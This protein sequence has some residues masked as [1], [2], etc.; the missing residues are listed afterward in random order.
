MAGFGTALGVSNAVWASAILIQSGTLLYLYRK[1]KRLKYQC[2]EVIAETNQLRDEVQDLKLKI[3]FIEDSQPIP[4]KPHYNVT[5]SPSIPQ[6]SA[7]DAA[8]L[9]PI[10]RVASVTSSSDFQDAYDEWA[11][12]GDSTALLN[13]TN[14]TTFGNPTSDRFTLD[15]N[16]FG[17]GG[18]G[19]SS[20]KKAD[21][22]HGNGDHQKCYDLL[23]EAASGKEDIE[24]LWRT[25]RTC[26]SLSNTVDQKSPKRKNL[27]QEGYKYAVAAY[28]IDDKNFNAVKWAAVLSGA[29]TDFLGTKEKIKEGFTFKE[30]LDKGLAINPTEYSLLHMRGRFSYNVANLGWLERKAAAAFFATPP[31][32]T[33]DEAIVDFAEV[34]KLKPEWVENL[35]YLAK[36]Y[37]A[38][39]Q[40][41]K[42]KACLNRLV[43]MESEDEADR[44]HIEEAKK[45]L[46]SL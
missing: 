6:S 10:S 32:A 22:L 13:R 35:I 45:L 14:D 25:A 26:H 5:F 8:V 44:E 4:Q 23:K 18:V 41:D 7:G 43:K 19:T 2:D 33:F 28:K 9:S 38:K 11:T 20:L 30:Y 46:K 16:D 12:S 1:L 27:I 39:G 36:S 31:T 40:K 17:N 42:A 24:T 34:D 3:R 15:K 37:I 21:E 29:L